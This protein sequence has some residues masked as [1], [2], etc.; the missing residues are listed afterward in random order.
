MKSGEVLEVIVAGG[1]RDCANE[2]F[3]EEKCPVL[4]VIT[5]GE[6]IHFKG[7]LNERKFQK[8]HTVYSLYLSLLCPSFIL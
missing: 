5:K 8:A 6:K 3:K 1:F 7:G 2:I 4:E